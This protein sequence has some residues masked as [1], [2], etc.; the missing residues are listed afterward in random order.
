MRAETLLL[1]YL[2]ENVLK[3][4][5]LQCDV[6]ISVVDPGILNPIECAYLKSSL[7]TPDA[8]A[9]EIEESPSLLW[10]ISESKWKRES[11]RGYLERAEK[12]F[13]QKL[14]MYEAAI[15]AVRRQHKK[16]ASY[17]A[18]KDYF[19]AAMSRFHSLCSG[20][21]CIDRARINWTHT[22]MQTAFMSRV[23]DR[24]F[25]RES[26]RYERAY[27]KV[28]TNKRADSELRS[29]IR[30]HVQVLECQ[31][32]NAPHKQV[33]F[34]GDGTFSASMKGHISVPKKSLVKLLAARGLVFLLDEYNTSKMCPCGHYE[35]EDKPDEKNKGTRLRC[36]KATGPGS[37][38]CVLDAFGPLKGDR[39]SLAVVNLAQ[40]ASCALTGKERPEHLK[41]PSKEKHPCVNPV[42]TTSIF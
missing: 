33:V 15:E 36:H 27:K 40:C 29:T 42:V 3:P 19:G 22:R 13:R 38:C 1:R 10:N 14:P 23:A 20:S 21:V 31:R 18:L 8:I 11:G 16:C 2:R 26:L 28:A 25:R 32:K 7:G 6:G 12:K 4:L 17:T 35:L 24:L 39:D 9:R 37:P 41:R 5:Q 34:F 30:K